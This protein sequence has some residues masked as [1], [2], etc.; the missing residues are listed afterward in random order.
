MRTLWGILLVGACVGMLRAQT[1]QARVDG[2]T[3]GD[4]GIYTSSVMKDIPD[5]NTAEGVRH[6][7][8]NISLQSRTETIPARLGVGFGFHYTITGAPNGAQVQI[9]FVNRFPD[10]GLKNPTTGETTHIEE[11][12]SNATVGNEMYKGWHFDHDYE[13]VPG[14]W[15]FE[16][17]YGNR[18]LGEQSFNVVAAQ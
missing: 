11:Y 4:P 3:I 13:L 5:A 14:T 1:T 10:P 8:G 7:V 6:T 16:I 2:A 15:T 9:R 12:S 17:W 18:K